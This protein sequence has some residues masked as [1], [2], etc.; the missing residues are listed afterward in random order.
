MDFN[1]TEEERMTRDCAREFA[2]KR[3]MSLAAELDE[4]GEFPAGLVTELAE[5]GLMGI[6]IPERWGGGGLSSTAYVLA[7]EEISRGCASVGV[8]MS[9]HIS[10]ACE[11]LARFGTDEQKERF[12][13]P[14]AT[15]KKIGALAMTEPEAGTDLGSVRL[16]AK[17]DGDDY[18]LNGTKIFITNGGVADVVLVLGSTDRA[19]G[20]RGLTMFVVEK[21]TPGFSVGRVEHKLG[22]RASNTAEL[23]FSDCRI[24]ASHRLGAEGEGYKIA[25]STLDGGR[26][27]IAA[28]AV[29]IGRAALEKALGYAK[30]RQQ[31]GKPIASFQAIQWML[32]D[33]ATELDAA[34]LLYLR[35]AWLKDQGVRFSVEAAMAKL[36]AS[37]AAGRAA[38]MAIQV[39]GGYGYTTEYAP[40]RHYRD[41]R[42]TRIYEGTSEAMRMVIASG[43]LR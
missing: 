39:H 30:Q 8:T 16:A 32:A 11:P 7:V 31:F 38:D 5:L 27:G 28:Q 1:L 10:L 42:I 34:R 17:R 41:A 23:I 25:L 20:S 19:A 3:L 33:C 24:P 2:E 22:I 21:G 9:A 35:A 4:K 12:L 37:E 14:L 13:K 18:V 36:F 6:P 43:L 26:I 15:G 40:E 29:G